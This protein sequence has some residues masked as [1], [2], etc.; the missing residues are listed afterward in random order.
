MSVLVVCVC[1]WLG[2]FGLPRYFLDLVFCLCKCGTPLDGPDYPTDHVG[3]CVR[4]EKD[5][6]HNTMQIGRAHV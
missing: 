5:S 1:C 2:L 3:S 4:V 6:R